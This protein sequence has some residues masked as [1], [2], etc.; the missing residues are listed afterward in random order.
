MQKKL[1]MVIVNYNDFEMTKR[2]LNNIKN[3][4]SLDEIVVVDNNSPD[5]SFEK[6]KEFESDRIAIIKNSNRQYASGLNVGAKYLIKKV[7]ECNIIFSNSDIIIKGEED[8]KKLSSN[9]RKDIVVVGPVVNEHGNLNRGWRIPTVNQ[10]ILFNI[11]LLNRYFKKKFLLYNE[12]LYKEDTT[13]VDVVS[14]CFFLVDSKFLMD[15]DYFDEGT[16]LYYEEQILAEKVRSQNKKELIDNRVTIIHDHSVSIDKSIKRIKKQEVLKAS[17]RYYAKNYK[18]ANKIQMALLY[19]TD[20]IHR[21]MLYI[22]CLVR[23]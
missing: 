5:N 7:G 17:Q 14:G 2:L 18:K 6:L 1:G 23:R 11:P 15:N 16:F 10:E 9:I 22:V 4:K 13:I 20:Y 19:I 8:L 12:N 21:I 3:Y